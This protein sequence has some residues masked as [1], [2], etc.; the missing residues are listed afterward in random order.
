MTDHHD[1]CACDDC[2]AEAE[3]LRA[4]ILSAIANGRVTE[5]SVLDAIIGS[6]DRP[7]IVAM[8]EDYRIQKEEG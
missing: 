8:V 1:D 2:E 3:E 7:E 4:L 5:D 6:T